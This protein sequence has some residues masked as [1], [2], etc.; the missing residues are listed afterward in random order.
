M[1]VSGRHQ[2]PIERCHRKY[3]CFL[4]A[5]FHHLRSD[6]PVRDCRLRHEA[7]AHRIGR[8]D[9][10]LWKLEID[11]QE[12]AQQT[13]HDYRGNSTR[14]IRIFAWQRQPGKTNFPSGGDWK[15]AWCRQSIVQQTLG[16]HQERRKQLWRVSQ[17]LQKAVLPVWNW[18]QEFERKWTEERVFGCW[19]H[20]EQSHK[21][22]AQKSKSVYKHDYFCLQKVHWLVKKKTGKLLTNLSFAWA[23]QLALR[24]WKLDRSRNPV[25]WLCWHY[26]PKIICCQGL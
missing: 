1:G 11:K 21:T 2:Q 25:E 19:E 13:S 8:K 6:H 16:E 4:T 9:S 14:G 10:R 7:K 5:S 17:G 24:R 15:Y 26:L 12:E 3:L 22:N 23:W 18:V 20:K